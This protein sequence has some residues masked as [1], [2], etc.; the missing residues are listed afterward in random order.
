MNGSIILSLPLALC[1]LFFSVQSVSAQNEISNDTLKFDFN[2]TNANQENSSDKPN[3][4]AST[5][6]KLKVVSSFFPIHEFVRK[7][8]G[9]NIESSLLIPAT[10]EPHDFEP[11]IN[12]I[13][14]A[15]SADVLVYNGLGIENWILKINTANKIDASKGL[16][17]SYAREDDMTLD[18]HI[19]LDPLLAKKQVENIRNGLIMVDPN[20][21]DSYFNNARIF[22]NDL[23]NLDKTIR[24]DLASCKKKDFITFHESFSYFAKE[25]GLNQHSIF[26]GGPEAEITPTRL[27]E[28]INVAKSL[29]LK[30]I[31]SEELIDSRYATVVAQEIPEGK[32]LVLSPIEGLTKDEQASGIGYIDKMKENLQNLK[33][34]LQCNQSST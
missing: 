20:N 26:K 33:V 34:G 21:K 32:V 29:D 6:S 12:Q 1:I 19:W 11:S 4:V 25:Y 10:V 31:Y 7:I 16:N 17:T 14:S 23:D 8:G 27:A 5:S 24:T 13:Q 2:T 22:L 3:S 18:P 15:N 28:I 9:D 30:V